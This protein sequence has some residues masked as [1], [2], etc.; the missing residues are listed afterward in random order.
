MVKF[1]ATKQDIPYV[2]ILDNQV[3]SKSKNTSTQDNEIAIIEIDQGRIRI[4]Q[5]N[6]LSIVPANTNTSNQLDRNSKDTTQDQLNPQQNIFQQQDNTYQQ[7]NLQHQDRA[8]PVFI[9]PE[10]SLRSRTT[11][12]E[13]KTPPV[14][15]DVNDISDLNSEDIKELVETLQKRVSYSGGSVIQ[16]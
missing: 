11:S 13:Y 6:I 15:P 2:V 16:E 12:Q 10:K 3:E 1:N 7:Y 9:T 8:P 14:S 4:E 5:A